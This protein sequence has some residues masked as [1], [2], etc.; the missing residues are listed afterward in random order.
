MYGKLCRIKPIRRKFDG[1]IIGNQFVGIEPPR[2]CGC[3]M[4]ELTE[5]RN[6][7]LF[8]DKGTATFG[9]CKCGETKKVEY[10]QR[11]TNSVDAWP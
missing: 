3:V 9:C 4:E 8:S 2:C 6:E 10:S 5:K 7:A 11:A 1:K